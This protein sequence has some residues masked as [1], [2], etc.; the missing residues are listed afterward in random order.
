MTPEEQLSELGAQ[1]VPEDAANS[2]PVTWQAMDDS[3]GQWYTFAHGNPPVRKNFHHWNHSSPLL[4]IQLSGC[5]IVL[6]KDGTWE[7]EGTMG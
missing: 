6:Y 2:P 3:P 1:F 7:C 5:G 4:W